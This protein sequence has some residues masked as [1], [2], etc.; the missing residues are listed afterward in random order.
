MNM[1][2][3][4]II[5]V[6]VLVVSTIGFGASL[7]TN[8]SINRIGGSDN[9]VVASA[10]GNVTA[11]AWT[12]E[13]NSTGVVAT[14]QIKFSVWNEDPT[15]AHSFQICAVL[16]GPSGVYKPSAGQSPACNSTASIPALTKIDLVGINFT[17][18]TT[19]KDIVDLSFSVEELN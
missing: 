14:K 13:V 3:L 4:A 16:E 19:V 2:L 6:A 12:E 5:G 7:T 17:T 8:P 11:L 15:N 10:R 9:N 18:T 1:S